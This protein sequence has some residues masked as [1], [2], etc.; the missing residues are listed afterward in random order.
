MNS[1]QAQIASLASGFAD[2]IFAALRGASLDD[3]AGGGSSKTSKTAFPVPVLVKA[4]RVK[5]AGK[6]G[7]LARRSPEDIAKGVASVVQLLAKSKIG[8]RAEEIR[9][10]LDLDV[11]EVPRILQAGLATRALRKTGNKRAT[12]YTARSAA[13]KK[14]AKPVPAKKAVK[15]KKATA[16]PAKKATAK[17]KKAV[18]KV[19]AKKVKP[20][21]K[22]IENLDA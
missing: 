11:R 9:T 16:K 2:A 12:V 1:L 18:K 21:A 4:P 13:E 6:S 7:R 8:L 22:P 3:L 19:A 14:A 20:A 15:A 5:R 17:K 10:Q